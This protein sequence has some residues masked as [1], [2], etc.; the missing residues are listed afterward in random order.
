MKKRTSGERRLAHH[1]RGTGSLG[2]ASARRGGPPDADWQNAQVMNERLAS[3]AIGIRHPAMRAAPFALAILLVVLLAS[4]IGPAALVRAQTEADGEV[5][6]AAALVVPD[7]FDE[8]MAVRVQEIIEQVPAVRELDPAPGVT[9]RLVDAATFRAELEVLFRDEYPAEHLEAEDDAF[10]R[11]GLLG[12]DDDLEELI[13]SL[14]EAQVLAY[15]DPRTDTF[16]LVGPLDEIGGLE[17]VVVAHEYGHALQDARWDLEGSRIRDLSRS[18]EI[19]AQQALAEGDATAV[20]YDWAARELRLLSLL[21]VAGDA[22]AR[23]DQRI[24]NRAPTILRRQL[25]FP[26][27]DGFAFVNALRGR[28]D[29]AAVDAAWDAR[30]VSSEQILHPELYP[31]ELPVE[32]VLPDVASLMGDGWTT[33]YVQTLGEMQIGVWVADGRKSQNLFPILPPQLPKQDAAA[34]WGGDR[35]A[36]LDGPDGSWAVVWQTDWDTKRDSDEFIKAARAA[37]KDLPGASQATRADIAGG[38]SSPVLVL[39]ADGE[40]TLAA[41]REALGLGA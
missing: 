7:G 1:R 33:S 26:Y 15:Y 24:L 25:E 8:A 38:L 40:G 23:D 9:Y 13:L 28:G 4:A 34:G 6:P 19:L 35:L 21:R 27:L 39:V 14:L 18:D 12:P 41:V 29:W 16:S 37:M 36:S 5:A 32:V 3:P 11:L 17:S 10:T 31:D 2:A 20:M 22:L 30:P